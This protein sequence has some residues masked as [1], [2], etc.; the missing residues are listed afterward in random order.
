[1]ALDGLLKNITGFSSGD[2]NVSQQGLDSL[3]EF[4]TALKEGSGGDGA[5]LDAI[6]E[7]GDTYT[8]KDSKKADECC[9]KKA[10]GCDS[11]DEDMDIKEVLADISESLDKLMASLEDDN[12]DDVDSNNSFV[13]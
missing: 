1:M 10:D 4:A 6:K 7:Y 3:A 13:A 9:E 2:K 12:S 5:S 11:G 8:A